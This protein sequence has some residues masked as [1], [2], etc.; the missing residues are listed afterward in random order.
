MKIQEY[1]IWVLRE[2]GDDGECPSVAVEL[3]QVQIDQ[4]LKNAYEWFNAHLGLFKVASLDLVVGQAEYDLSAVTPGIDDI[5][6]V[7]YEESQTF[8][9]YDGLYPGF[10]DIDGFP[11]V[12]SNGDTNFPQ[13]TH[14]QALQNLKTMARTYSSDWDWEFLNENFVDG[15][16]VRALTVSPVPTR[17]GKA[18]YQYRVD[19]ADVK[20]RM[21]KPKHLWLIKQ[22]AL[23]C[24]KIM[25]GRKRGKFPGG[26]PVAGS[27][28]PMDGESLVAEGREDKDRLDLKIIEAGGPVRPILG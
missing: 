16:P 28:R 10:L 23:A 1:R 2:L 26:L 19:P 5:M 4:S 21:F 27:D 13:T 9:S 7:W 25:L 11:Y 14:V 22:Y 17:G 6:D 18:I 20:T 3:S 12:G 24:A 8:A 15:S